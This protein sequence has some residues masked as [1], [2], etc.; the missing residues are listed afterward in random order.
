M[1]TQ[2]MALLFHTH[3]CIHS[4]LAKS[5]QAS[6][7]ILNLAREKTIFQKGIRNHRLLGTR[8]KSNP[9]KR[10]TTSVLEA[11]K[12]VYVKT[13]R[14]NITIVPVLYGSFVYNSMIVQLCSFKYGSLLF[15]TKP[16]PGKCRL[17]LLATSAHDRNLNT[18][19]QN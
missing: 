8:K 10:T 15:L 4:A 6:E 5:A 18:G 7:C 17:F 14:Q 2:R 1:L 11:W 3:V 13:K 16:L 19:K 9:E 12:Y